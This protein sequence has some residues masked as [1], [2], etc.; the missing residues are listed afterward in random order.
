MMRLLV[1]HVV[2]RLALHSF[3]Y[4]RLSVWANVVIQKSNATMKCKD[5]IAVNYQATIVNVRNYKSR[6]IEA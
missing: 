6:T 3:M 4:H 2:C 5:E 1:H